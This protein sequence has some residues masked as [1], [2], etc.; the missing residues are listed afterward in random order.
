MYVKVKFNPNSSMLKSSD[1]LKKEQRLKTK[2]IPHLA[3]KGK[4]IVTDGFEMRVW[5]DNKISP[6]FSISV[7]TAL[8]KRAVIRNKVKRRFKVAVLELQKNNY[9]FRNGK[10]LIIVRNLN[11]L[12]KSTSELAKQIKNSLQN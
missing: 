3:R 12:E 4:K 6:A 11:V 9:R 7:S 2:D 5:W 10:Y 1:M 8:D